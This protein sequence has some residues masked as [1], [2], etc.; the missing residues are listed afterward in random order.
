[1]Y[2]LVLFFLLNTRNWC[3]HSETCI[4]NRNLGLLILTSL[5]NCESNVWRLFSGVTFNIIDCLLFNWYFIKNLIGGDVFFIR[6][7]WWIYRI[8]FKNNSRNVFL[9]CSWF[10]HQLHVFKIKK[11]IYCFIL[12]QISCFFFVLK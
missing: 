4:L 12:G 5:T 8:F 2:F 7:F 11:K 1:M 9:D 3:F 10:I 6:Q